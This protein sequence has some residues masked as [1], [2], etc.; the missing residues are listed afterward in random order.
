MPI[1]LPKNYLSY[2]AMTCWLTNKERFRREYF[3]NAEKLETKYLHFGKMA[4]KAREGRELKPG[5]IT[6]YEIRVEI[7]GVPILS[8]LDFY[9]SNNNIFEE[10]KTGKQPWTHTRVHQHEQLVYYATALR[11]KTGKMP[12]SCTLNWFETREHEGGGLHYDGVEFTGLVK[13]FP[14][15]LD[16]RECDRMEELI[17]KVAEEISEAYKKYIEEEI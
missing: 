13:N 12:Q 5:E 2:S 17:L 14:R 7:K 6:E 1:I 10:D 9:D 11:A 16:E 8:Y 15:V 4:A 3:E